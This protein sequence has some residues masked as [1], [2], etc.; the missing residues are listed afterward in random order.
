MRNKKNG[1]ALSLEISEAL[2]AGAL[3]ALV[4]NSEN[5]VDQ[6]NIGTPLS[7]DG[8]AEPKVLSRGKLFDGLREELGRETGKSDD[9]REGAGDFG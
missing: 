8:K 1:G 3:E 7:G 4:A 5:F 6:E 2:E 9:F